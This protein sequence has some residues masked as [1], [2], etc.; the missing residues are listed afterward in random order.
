MTPSR[1]D[2]IALVGY[3]QTKSR[4]PMRMSRLCAVLAVTVGAPLVYAEFAIGAALPANC[5]SPAGEDWA[6]TTGNLGAW[7]NTSLPPINKKNIE[8]P[9]PAWATHVPAD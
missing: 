3:L 4:S 1:G 7:G 6:Y 8:Q 2:K 5:C 9:G